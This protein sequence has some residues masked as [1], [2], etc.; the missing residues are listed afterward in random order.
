[1]SQSSS[2][3]KPKTELGRVQIQPPRV[4]F[5]LL[6]PGFLVGNFQS[7]SLPVAVAKQLVI[8]LLPTLTMFRLKE[9]WTLPCWMSLADGCFFCPLGAESEHQRGFAVQTKYLD[10]R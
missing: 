6:A 9:G 10:Q 7:F 2:R 8:H 1:M 4:R 3:I 5:H